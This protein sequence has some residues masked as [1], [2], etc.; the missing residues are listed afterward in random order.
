MKRVIVASALASLLVGGTALAAP[1]INGT[2]TVGSCAL[3]GK[4]KIK[5]ALQTGNTAPGAIKAKAKST[6]CSGGT[7][8]GATVVSAKV[9]G[10]GTTATSDCNGLVGTQPSNLTVEI[11][12]KVTKGSPKLATS[13]VTFTSQTGGITGD[14]HGSFDLTGSVTAGSFMGN[15]V[16]AHVETDA[17]VADILNACGGKGIKKITFGANGASNASL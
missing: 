7:L 1:P 8:D 11:K 4:I 9:K 10:A 17:L 15:P 13:T 2:G 16:S 6:S 14:N 5:P 12:W 3:I